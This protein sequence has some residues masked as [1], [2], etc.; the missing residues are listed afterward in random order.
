MGRRGNNEGSVYK[1][2][3]G[4]WCAAITTGYS[5][6]TGRAIRAYFYADT[7]AEVVAKRDD[8][9]Q[10]VKA[11]TY[12]KPQ[13]KTLGQWLDVWLKEYV[14][15]SVRPKTW[16]GY[17]YIVRVHLRPTLGQMELR[18]LQTNHVQ[19]LLNEKKKSG[20]SARTVELICV[21]LKAALKQ[22]QLEGLVTRNAADHVRKPKKE[23]KKALRVLSS[24]EMDALVAE[25][26]KHR[27]APLFIT[28]LGTGLRIGE[29][30]ALEWKDID[31]QKGALTVCQSVVRSRTPESARSISITQDP[32]S[33]SGKRTIPL[34]DDV[35]IA[36][37]QWRTRQAQERL[38][39][40]SLYRDSGRVYTS[41]VGTPLEPRNV[42]RS[43]SRIASL[44]RVEHVNP[45]ALRHT[46]ATRLLERG[47]HPKVVQELLGHR[48]I[49][50]T[51]NTYSHVMPEIKQAAA[52]ALSGMFKLGK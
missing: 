33:G 11:G 52:E 29:A 34:T 25:A 49:T 24:T 36:L 28:M 6:D 39:L 31:L 37:R 47:V 30:I 35:I 23:R 21:T 12:V 38:K 1:R 19:H 20:L 50:L 43:L 18:A 13:K 17:D 2:K 22:A 15:P 41:T 5:E 48:D 45:H 16:E 51:L 46:Y 27:L 8:A 3:D 10:L 32:K 42:A 9:L 26:L 7:R 44:A 40:G 14:A 4:R